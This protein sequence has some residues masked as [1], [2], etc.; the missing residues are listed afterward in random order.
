M[1]L[2]HLSPLQ[3]YIYIYIY[4][5]ICNGYVRDL[6]IYLYNG[7]ESNLQILIERLYAILYLMAIVM[8]ALSVIVFNVDT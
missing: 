2:P 4:I 7:P 6:E 3:I 5:Y 1:D 8:F